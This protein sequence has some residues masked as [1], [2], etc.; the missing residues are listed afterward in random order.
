MGI[1][2]VVYLN[3]YAE[4]KGIAHDEGIDFLVKFGV[5]AEKYKGQLSNV[6]HMI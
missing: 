4:H 5:K 6:T 1:Q 3:S 2:H